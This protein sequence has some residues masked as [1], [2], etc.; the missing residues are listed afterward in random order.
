MTGI[1]NPNL[2]IASNKVSE[3]W[4]RVLDT[5]IQ[6]DKTIEA[7]R[8]GILNTC[9]SLQAQIRFLDLVMQRQ[10]KGNSNG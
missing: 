6:N 2:M 4:L 8:L 1:Q 7:F 5:D 9:Q 3:L 10:Q